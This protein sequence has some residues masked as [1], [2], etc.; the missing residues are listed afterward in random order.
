MER[1]LQQT[2]ETLV[3]EHGV[4]AVLEALAQVC[5]DKSEHV[6]V[7]WQDGKLAA[8]WSDAGIAVERGAARV[9]ITRLAQHEGR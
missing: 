2:L 8:L 5:F 1:D 4:R 6:Q 3:D 9:G 7:Q